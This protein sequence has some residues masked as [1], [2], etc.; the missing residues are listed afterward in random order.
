MT[1]FASIFALILQA[2]PAILAFITALEGKPV[3]I[4]T[5]PNPTITNS[6]NAAMDAGGVTDPTQRSVMHAMVHSAAQHATATSTAK[7]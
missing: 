6:T 5:T 1:T 7:K 2:L 4:T 3:Q